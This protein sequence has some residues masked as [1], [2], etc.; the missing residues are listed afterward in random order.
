MWSDSVGGWQV[1]ADA[2]MLTGRFAHAAAHSADKETLYVVGGS[3]CQPGLDHTSLHLYHFNQKTWSCDPTVKLH[4]SRCYAGAV[5]SGNKLYVIGGLDP[6]YM[7]T[8]SVEVHDCISGSPFEDTLIPSLNFARNAQSCAVHGGKIYVSGGEDGDNTKLQS[9]EVFN[10]Q[11][12]PVPLQWSLL[13][14][15]MPHARHNHTSVVHGNKLYVILVFVLVRS[16]C[17]V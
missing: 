13:P 8:S 7:V 15:D 10:T 5:V 6:D 2:M 4:V 14:T 11:L 9:V 1:R 3:Q 17:L 12:M 16:W